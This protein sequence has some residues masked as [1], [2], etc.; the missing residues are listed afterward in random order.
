MNLVVYLAGRVDP[1]EVVL[2]HRVLQYEVKESY[3]NMSGIISTYFYFGR[4]P[5]GVMRG[6]LKEY[7]EIMANIIIILP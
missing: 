5:N 7:M 1:A 6:Q 3:Q 2:V 4:L